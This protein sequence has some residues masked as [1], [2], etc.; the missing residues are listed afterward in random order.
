VQNGA[1]PDQTQHGG[2]RF[3]YSFDIQPRPDRVEKTALPYRHPQSFYFSGVPR[4]P[5]APLP[6]APIV[7]QN[8]TDFAMVRPDPATTWA[9]VASLDPAKL[10]AYQLFN[11]PAAATPGLVTN[12][13]GAAAKIPNWGII[14]QH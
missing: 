1:A 5:Q 12:A 4:L 14:G 6:D 13:P 3:G 10:P 2:I 7:S 8:Y 11:P 9:Q